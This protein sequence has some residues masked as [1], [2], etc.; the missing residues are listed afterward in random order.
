VLKSGFEINYLAATALA[1]EAAIL[2]NYFWHQRFTWIDRPT[3]NSD[4]RFLK[5]NFTT[6]IFSIL[7]NVVLMQCFVVSLRMNYLL[8]NMLTIATC[9]LVNFVV[10]DRFVFEEN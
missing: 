5:F 2:H 3:Q 7:G 9:S 4:C 6:G 10:S 8:A 1:V